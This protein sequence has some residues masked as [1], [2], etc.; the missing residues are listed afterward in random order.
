MINVA[1]PEPFDATDTNGSDH[2][3]VTPGM[4]DQFRATGT[5]VPSKP[6]TL[7]NATV[8]L[9]VCPFATLLLLELTATLKFPSPIYEMVVEAP[10]AWSRRT[11]R[12]VPS[13][14]STNGPSVYLPSPSAL[15]AKMWTVPSGKVEVSLTVAPALAVP[16][17]L[18]LVIPAV[19]LPGESAAVILTPFS[20]RLTISINPNTTSNGR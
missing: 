18:T 1:E 19:G 13:C 20:L 7:V 4:C 17:M 2:H 5:T 10:V 15:S 14:C 9:A 6:D 11:S 3:A 12:K 8:Y 16:V